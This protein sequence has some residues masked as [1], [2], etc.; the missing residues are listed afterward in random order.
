MNKMTEYTAIWK[1]ERG[2]VC[3]AETSQM[4]THVLA[5]CSSVLFFQCVFTHSI[6]RSTD[7]GAAHICYCLNWGR[8]KK[9]IKRGTF[10]PFEF[11]LSFFFLF[12]L[13]SFWTEITIK[14]I[15]TKKQSRH[16]SNIR[17]FILRAVICVY[18]FWSV[19]AF[20][21]SQWNSIYQFSIW[22]K[23]G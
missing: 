7:I 10:Y 12:C 17:F 19:S 14:D 21:E 11:R 13:F 9:I 15:L 20:G 8:K 4:V 3:H 18:F 6:F 22:P 23:W 2:F 1:T 5:L 16:N